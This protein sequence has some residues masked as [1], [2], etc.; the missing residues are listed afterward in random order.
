MNGNNQLRHEF[1]SR[2]QLVLRNNHSE[3]QKYDA[4][5][6]HRR[7]RQDLHEHERNQQRPSQS[8]TSSNS[9][10]PPEMEWV[11]YG[12]GDYD[13]HSPCNMEDEDGSS[14]EY[15]HDIES[16]NDERKTSG[17]VDRKNGSYGPAAA[18]PCGDAASV[19][20]TELLIAMP[21]ELSSCDIAKY[22]EKQRQRFTKNNKPAASPSSPSEEPISPTNST[23]SGQ[24][25]TLHGTPWK[26]RTHGPGTE[27][28]VPYRILRGAT[29]QVD[30]R[31]DRVDHWRP[32]RERPL[33][34]IPG[35]FVEPRYE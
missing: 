14:Y 7:S 23:H 6:V 12:S 2:G 29:Y 31:Y 1:S 21:D 30:D 27:V 22:D 19:A 8:Q 5:Q 34:S 32:R 26:S 25:E 15:P 3:M 28:R 18:R 9:T 24:F 20:N 17:D 13:D 35:P 10:A 33:G 4:G 16:M 11:I